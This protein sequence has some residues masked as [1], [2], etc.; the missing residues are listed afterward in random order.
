MPML[1][2]LLYSIVTM[3]IAVPIVKYISFEIRIFIIRMTHNFPLNAR[4]QLKTCSLANAIKINKEL[5]TAMTHRSNLLASSYENVQLSLIDPTKIRAKAVNYLSLAS[6][7][8]CFARYLPLYV[9]RN[10]R[11]SFLFLKSK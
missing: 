10:L 4:A 9:G 11:S 2:G 3:M 6:K 1:I 8:I 7:K 5:Q